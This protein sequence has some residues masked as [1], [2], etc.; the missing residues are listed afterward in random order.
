MTTNAVYRNPIAN[1][2]L[3][4]TISSSCRSPIL[5]VKFCNLLNPFYYTNSPTVPRY[6]I[7]CVIDPNTHKDFLSS[8]QTIEKNEKVD[9]VLKNET[10][11]DLDI[12]VNTGKVLLKF[13]SKNRI[14]IYIGNEEELQN[15]DRPQILELEDEL[16][17]GE[18]IMIIY[19]ITRYTKKNTMKTE[20]GISFKPSCIYYFPKK[21]E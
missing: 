20:H 10:S 4:T 16:A 13:Q 19:D 14:P 18:R 9:S 7:T 17:K 15:E 8:I 1:K 6:S 3:I 11:K 21:G 12:L 2:A 5:E